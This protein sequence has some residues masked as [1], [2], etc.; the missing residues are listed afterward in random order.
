MR[1]ATPEIEY[2]GAL[3]E[4]SKAILNAESE[5]EIAAIREEIP[6]VLNERFGYDSAESEVFIA[7]LNNWIKIIDENDIDLDELESMIE[8]VVNDEISA[9]EA[10]EI[11][12]S[13]NSTESL[14]ETSS[15]NPQNDVG[16][17]AG[18]IGI[19]I[20]IFLGCYALKKK[21]LK[22]KFHKGL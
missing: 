12:T 9:E 7:R 6:K 19:G 2:Y 14:T 5:E 18:G 17:A 16:I 13:S 10:N 4:F 21:L 20:G 11:L 22:S 8:S 1:E 3:L 15:V